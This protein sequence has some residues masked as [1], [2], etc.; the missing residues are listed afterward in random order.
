ME[1]LDNQEQYTPLAKLHTWFV[2]F[3]KSKY[4]ENRESRDN[5]RYYHGNQLSKR[6]RQELEKRKQPPIV[7]NFIR[8]TVDGIVGL[9]TRYRQDPKAYPRTPAHLEQSDIAT[10]SIRYVCDNNDWASLSTDCIMDASQSGIM[11]DEFSLEQDARGQSELRIKRLE[12]EKFFYDPKS[13]KGDFSDAL[14]MG[15][16]GWFDLQ[17]AISLFP[18]KADELRQSLSGDLQGYYDDQQEDWTTRWYD[19]SKELTK[20]IEMWYKEDGVWKYCFF[21]GAH[22][23][24]EGTSP[25]LDHEGN[26]GCRFV[27]QSAYVDESGD[28]YSLIRDLRPLQDEINQ[29]RSKMLHM[30]N[31][32]QTW[33]RSGAFKSVN[34]MRI[35]MSRP[36]GHIEAEGE[37]GRDWGVIDQNDQISGQAALLESSKQEME[38][39]GPGQALLGQGGLQ[40]SSGRALALHLQAGMAKMQPF[41]NRIRSWKL[42][43]YRMIWNNIQK[44]WEQERYIL[45]TDDPNDI[46]HIPINSLQIDE[47]GQPSLQNNLAQMDMDIIID[48]SPDTVTLQSE[49]FDKIVSLVQAGV[50]FPSDVLIEAS[51]L[52]GKTKAKMLKKLEEQQQ[53]DP[54]AAQAAQLELAERSIDIQKVQSEIANKNADTEKK[55]AETIEIMMQP[56]TLANA[57]V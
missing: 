22:K 20:I 6:V 9:D 7:S 43:N 26:S 53:Q 25:F 18:D 17:T 29:R 34:D 44:Y 28:R 8:Q 56:T 47:Y 39:F 15:S 50:Q 27:P 14:Y 42:R 38:S 46:Q 3:S 24:N 12:P 1:N 2:D 30:I 40:D 36:D 52:D 13:I 54:M 57:T 19:I 45:V 51:D 32:R 4:D 10:A 31:T 41:F 21:T 37:F 23:L 16:W 55:E 11:I 33:A 35:Q 5:R 48:E 49:T